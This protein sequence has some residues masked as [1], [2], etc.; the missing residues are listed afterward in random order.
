MKRRRTEI[1]DV[2]AQSTAALELPGSTFGRLLVEAAHRAANGLPPSVE[3]AALPSSPSD[4][5][6]EPLGPSGGISSSPRQAPF[7]D[8]FGEWPAPS[9]PQPAQIDPRDV[10]VLSSR[11]IAPGGSPLQP[12]VP[13]QT[14]QPS[15]SPLGAG[16]REPVPRYPVAPEIFGLPDRSGASGDNMDDWLASWMPLLR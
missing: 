11:L 15:G 12:N 9:P 3:A 10:R 2:P 4:P 14:E 7:N 6:G 5:A 13:G 16:S 1:P 8:R